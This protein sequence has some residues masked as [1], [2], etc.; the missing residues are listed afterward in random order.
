[1]T[2]LAARLAE[3][4]RLRGGSGTDSVAGSDAALRRVLNWVLKRALILGAMSSGAMRAP[5]I[6]LNQATALK[7][8]CNGACG[9]PGDGIRVD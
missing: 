6:L 3:G 7:L 2:E 1:V 4:Q 8:I 5:R 9:Q